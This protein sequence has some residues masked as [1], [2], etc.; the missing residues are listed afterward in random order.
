MKTTK[1]SAEDECSTRSAPPLS[2][3]ETCKAEALYEKF[4]TEKRAKNKAYAFI[5][6]Y[7][8]LS[9]YAAFSRLYENEAENLDG[10]IRLVLQ[11]K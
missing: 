4:L 7:G 9:E 3:S 5:L 1:K 2:K 6:S 10:R 11:T 8:L